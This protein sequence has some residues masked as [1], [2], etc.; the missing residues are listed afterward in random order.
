VLLYINFFR[1]A[2]KEKT[3]TPSSGNG[4][5]LLMDQHASSPPAPNPAMSSDSFSQELTRSLQP[6]NGGSSSIFSQLTANPFLTAVRN[7]SLA[8]MARID[9]AYETSTSSSFFS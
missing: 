5:P 4:N 1:F 7:L 3:Q 8:Q 2:P 6:Q 9:C